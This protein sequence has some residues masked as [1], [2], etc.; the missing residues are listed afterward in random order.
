VTGVSDRTTQ[1]ADAERRDIAAIIEDECIADDGDV[2]TLRDAAAELERLRAEVARLEAALTQR[3]EALRRI[4]EW[5]PFEEW[6]MDDQHEIHRIALAGSGGAE[7]Q[8]P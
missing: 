8:T 5:V 7:E 1:T 4:A 6:D 3:D 2:A